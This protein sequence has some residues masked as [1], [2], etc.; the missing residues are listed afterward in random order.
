MYQ[1]L[2]SVNDNLLMRQAGEWATEKLDYLRRYID[3]FE[4]SMRGK[5]HT[6]IY[7]D[8]LAGPGKNRISNT[9]NV[10]L[11]SPL[12]ALKTRFPFTR[13]YFTDANAANISALQ[14]R[15]KASPYNNRIHTQTGDCNQLIDNIVVE[16]KQV[17]N[18]SLNLA[19][20][21]PEGLELHWNTV[22]KLA[23]IKRMDM[24]IIYP[25]GGLNRIMAK[26]YNKPIETS[27]DLFFGTSEWREIYIKYKYQHKSGHHREL[28]DL[29]KTQLQ[30]L[31]YKEVR[32]GDEAGGYEPLM[33]NTKRNA[34]LYRLIF[35]S[36]NPLG[37]RFW[38]AITKRN[39]YGQR[40]LL[41]SI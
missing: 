33:R 14:E 32:R 34:P 5:W 36:K 39:V 26:I 6:R 21:D 20:L 24:I 40:R 18:N 9:K 41:D 16:L 27:V 25:E 30:A 4:T 22:A 1:Y 7:L 8:L 10:V 2:D 28:I 13:Y 38:Q 3:V 37:E 31:G 19:F 35:A 15:C 29:Y 11:G 12:I 17:E 23:D